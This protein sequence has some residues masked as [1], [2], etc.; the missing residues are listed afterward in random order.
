MKTGINTTIVT[1]HGANRLKERCKVKNNR[2]VE[3]NV[4][5]A[6]QRGKHAA[7]CTSWEKVFLLKECHS[8][9]TAIAYNG[10]CYVF[11]SNNVCVTLYPLP[12]WFGKKKHFNGKERIRKFKKYCRA[13]T[14][15]NDR[16][17]LG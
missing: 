9:C 17:A 1:I 8:D 13:H 15:Y 6:L 7:D 16:L 12:S 14:P 10:F 11:N 5:R 2:S 4:T 3:K